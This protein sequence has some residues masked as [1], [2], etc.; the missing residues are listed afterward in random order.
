MK[1][2]LLFYLLV[3]GMAWGQDC[4][5]IDFKT[6]AWQAGHSVCIDDWCTCHVPELEARFSWRKH[7]GDECAGTGGSGQA[8]NGPNQDQTFISA[9]DC[10]TCDEHGACT[11]VY[12][13]APPAWVVNAIPSLTAP[14]WLPE[15]VP[16]IQELY[17][18]RMN[19]GALTSPGE[20]AGWLQDGGL[21]ADKRPM[22]YTCSEKSRIL[23]HDENTP[24][25][26]W[27]H[28]P[29]THEEK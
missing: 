19:C 26:F 14:K 4:G 29:N 2:S 21:C 8:N 22:I 24:P 28:A 27:C 3:T 15:D 25:K 12:C 16:A 18:G 11:L 17:K 23:Q 10:N 13:M 9:G 5:V 20:E 7:A 6:G 1:T